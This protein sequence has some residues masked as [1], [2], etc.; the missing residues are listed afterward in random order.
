MAQA[1]D[2]ERK[3]FFERAR[4]QAE[5]DY[6][7]NKRDASALTRWGGALLELA[8]YMPSDEAPQYVDDAV[9]K[10][11][12]ALTIDPRRDEALWCLGNA[13]TSQG[14]LSPQKMKAMELFARAKVCVT[15]KFSVFL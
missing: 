6:N 3:D 15:F 7:K 4:R 2:A 9:R 10:F 11:Q 1:T 14:F 12:E 5:D 8:N 13:Y